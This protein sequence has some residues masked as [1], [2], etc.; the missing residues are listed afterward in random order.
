[1]LATSNV[2]NCV[3]LSLYYPMSYWTILTVN[4][5]LDS[6]T[7]LWFFAVQRELKFSVLYWVIF[8]HTTASCLLEL[9]D[10]Q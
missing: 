10:R 6:S 3:T 1:M 9:H 8:S 7:R 4:S 5:L 2:N